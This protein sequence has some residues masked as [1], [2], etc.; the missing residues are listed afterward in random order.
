MKEKSDKRGVAGLAVMIA[1]S[2]IL[3]P[4]LIINLTLII[5]GNINTDIPPDVFGIAPL[6]VTSGS[7]EGENPDSFSTGALIF[8]EILSE[9]EKAD[10]AVDDIVTFRS[11]D[12]YVTHRIVSLVTEG[13]QLRSVVTRGDA[14][15]ATDGAI[16]LSNVV[17][18]CV[19]SIA[20]L[21]SFSM[22][23][24]TPGGIL[25][26]VGIPVLAFIAYDILRITLYNRRVRAEAAAADSSAKLEDKE[27]ELREKEEE[28]ERLRALVGAQNGQGVSSESG[29]TAA[30]EGAES[31]AEGQAREEPSGKRE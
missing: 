15:N 1:V 4:I 27:R 21:G 2:V 19:G 24:Q 8:V 31:A 23:L 10:L 12:S 18:R 14:N 22:F 7:M 17:G 28:L 13:G 25:V 30:R 26:F 16:P 20:G 11:G 5:K 9:E 6:A 3:I 29:Q